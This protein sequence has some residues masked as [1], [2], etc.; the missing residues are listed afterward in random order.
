MNRKLFPSW[1]LELGGLY[2]PQNR[3]STSENILRSDGVGIGCVATAQATKPLFP[4]VVFMRRSTDRTGTGSIGR[5]HANK[6][7]TVL[8]RF[9]FD[10]VEHLP[11]C[12]RRHSFTKRFSSTFLFASLHIQKRF[13]A[14]IFYIFLWIKRNVS[15]RP[16]QLRA[17]PRELGTGRLI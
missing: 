12:P 17:R 13:H 4:A 5:T 6:Q 10:S 15:R 7:N 9:M 1:F 11:I 8:L 16:K 14:I 3:Q 2:A